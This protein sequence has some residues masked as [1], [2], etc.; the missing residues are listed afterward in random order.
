MT[1]WKR[2]ANQSIRRGLSVLRAMPPMRGSEWAQKHFYLSSESSYTEGRWQAY[3]YQNF[4]L[5]VFC[6]DDVE[7]VSVRKSARTGYTKMLLA[8]SAFFTT[9]R[10]RNQAIWQPTDSDRDEFVDSEYDPMLRDVYPI[11]K[12]FPALE[13]KHK[14]NKTNFKR[15]IGCSTYLKGGTSARNYR[16]ISVDVAIQDE[17]DGFDKDIDNEGSS[18][19][20]AKK[21][22]EGA[23]FP[24]HICG[25]TPKLKY[26]SEIDAAIEESESV[27]T[28]KIPCPHCGTLQTLEFGGK[29]KKHGLKWFND[30]PTTAA[31]ACIDCSSLFT[32]AD[33]LKIWDKGRWEDG[34]GNWYC[35]ET[36]KFYNADGMPIRPPKSIGID[37]LWA[38]YSPQ[39]TWVKIVK[40]FLD[41]VKK[42]KQGD[43]SALKA[44]VNTTL[45]ESYEEDAE[46]T[47]ADELKKRA[48]DFPIG[49]VPKGGL[50][51]FSF[52]DVQK[53]R[54][55]LLVWA[56]G[57]DEEMWTVDYQV[58]R[59]NPVIAQEW[60][61]LD[62]FILKSY[63]HA[64]GTRLSI[65]HVGIDT[66]NWT[67]ESYHYVRE[68]YR[69]SGWTGLKPGQKPPKIY[70]TK[71]ASTYGLKIS[72]RPSKQDVNA[73]GRVIRK[74][75][76]LYKIGTDTAKNTIFGRL[77]LEEPGACYMHLSKHLP[78]VFFEHMTNE[79]RVTKQTSRGEMTIWVP[80]K[81]GARNEC[82][83]C[84]VGVL[85]IMDKLNIQ[86]R[87]QKEWDFLESV[88]QPA[89]NDLF[90]PPLDDEIEIENAPQSVPAPPPRKQPEL[91][92]P[93]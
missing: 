18:R 32:Q 26:L 65:E 25:S 67:H 61:K 72:G 38:I 54:F 31:Y 35:D 37:K 13:K 88:V 8:A 63:R 47:D 1:A 55:E 53:D 41:A 56:V 14:H 44:F 15:F 16:R 5:D 77:K 90:S 42:A 17:V 7:E 91:F 30:D 74:G 24:K 82:L 64:C 78:D 58:I 86:G 92:I 36:G 48:E 87:S 60:H 59:A 50:Q 33:Y 85:F 21:R 39:T 75:V 3:P 66:G 2:T 19:K 70:A 34:H 79:V 46:K 20:L 76:S 81:S 71:G 6:N 22:L 10:R 9:F 57:R 45:G 28:R 89:Q 68:R 40:E 84:T 51:L 49:I 83:D 12:V 62:P 4:I 69:A 27:Y 11:K 93:E 29:D 73:F 80:R 43:K 52:V 23:T